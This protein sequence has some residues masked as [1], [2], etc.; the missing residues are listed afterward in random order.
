MRNKHE[1]LELM[2]EMDELDSMGAPNPVPV[3]RQTYNAYLLP[4]AQPLLTKNY[5][6][7]GPREQVGS[8]TNSNFIK[9][10]PH[11]NQNK[12]TEG[13]ELSL[14]PSVPPQT[15]TRGLKISTPPTPRVIWRP[16]PVP[17]PKVI[18][19]QDPQI[20]N[21]TTDPPRPSIKVKVDNN[22]QVLTDKHITN[23]RGEIFYNNSH[24]TNC[25]TN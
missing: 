2:A 23:K 15:Q 20:T 9:S 10:P 19:P 22:N 6:F 25:G 3:V 18:K 1:E 17:R 16:A 24:F 21:F 4:M 11:Q 5:M 13:G 7:P 8:N 14:P 12:G